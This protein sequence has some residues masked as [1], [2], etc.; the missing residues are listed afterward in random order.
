MFGEPTRTV[1]VVLPTAGSSQGDRCH[2]ASTRSLSVPLRRDWN[3]QTTGI[4]CRVPSLLTETQT[5]LRGLTTEEG[6]PHPS[7]PK[8][9]GGRVD[10]TWVLGK[11]K[12]APAVP[13]TTDTAHESQRVLRDTRVRGSG[14]RSSGEGPCRRG[15]RS[16]GRTRRPLG[17]V[18]SA[19][20]VW[21]SP[22]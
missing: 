6:R 14:G 2:G 7:D 5:A 19:A 1:G 22:R 16:H 11:S 15:G 17:R 18:S 10:V 8:D 4:G 13:G 3:S 12:E 9:G 21:E 20:D